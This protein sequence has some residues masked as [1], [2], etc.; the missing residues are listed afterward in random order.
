MPSPP[1]TETR[2]HLSS[3]GA[4]SVFT[5]AS[6]ALRTVSASRRWKRE[7]TAKPERVARCSGGYC[8]PG[9]LGRRRP[10]SPEGWPTAPG[11]PRC[12]R[13]GGGDG[14]TAVAHR[15]RGAFCSRPAS[16]RAPIPYTAQCQC[17]RPVLGPR[18]EC[19]SPPQPMELILAEH[20]AARPS[21]GHS[22]GVAL[23]RPEDLLGRE[24]EL[25]LAAATRRSAEPA[26][27]TTVCYLESVPCGETEESRR[28]GRVAPEGR[29]AQRQDG[30]HGVRADPSRDRG[31][32]RRGQTSV[33]SRCH[34][35]LSVAE[36]STAR[37]RG[38]DGEHLQRPRPSATAQRP[39]SHGS[40]AS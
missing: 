11:W 18:P 15:L 3:P 17:V 40:T 28:G 29:N 27:G 19:R 13:A 30:T 31:G 32:H 21:V 24:A 39:S 23:H 38:A 12:R 26:D 37:G 36:A 25:L 5:L 14:V 35:W 22:G 10:P 16:T 20:A 8:R 1:R 7:A 2:R 34:S 33:S 9:P 4:K 6:P